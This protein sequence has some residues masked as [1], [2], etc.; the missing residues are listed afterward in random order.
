MYIALQSLL[1]TC[2]TTLTRGIVSHMIC[3]FLLSLYGL[4][5][6]YKTEGYFKFTHT[7]HVEWDIVHDV[8]GSRKYAIKVHS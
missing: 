8:T 1:K 7:V 5:P 4:Q 3:Y 6:T 2:I